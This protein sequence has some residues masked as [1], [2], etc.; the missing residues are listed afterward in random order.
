MHRLLEVPKVA[1][2]L[3]LDHIIDHYYL[4]HLKIN[5]YATI[6]IGVSNDIADL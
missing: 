6:P 5:P 3:R 1:E 2:T 4:S